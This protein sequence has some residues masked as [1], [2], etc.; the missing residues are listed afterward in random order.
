M[1]KVVK[2]WEKYL[3]QI[4]MQLPISKDLSDIKADLK[5]IRKLMLE[6]NVSASFKQT[7][8]SKKEYK[9]DEPVIVCR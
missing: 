4:N 3:Q 1:D 8:N 5:Q 6:G 2:W 9:D 7:A